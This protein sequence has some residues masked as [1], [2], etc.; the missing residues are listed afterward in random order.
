MIQLDSSKSKRIPVDFA[1]YGANTVLYVYLYFVCSLLLPPLK[2]R[3]LCA[4][5]PLVLLS[6][7][8]LRSSA[9]QAGLQLFSVVCFRI[10][11][12]SIECR[13]KKCRG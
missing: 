13:K 3:V 2:L 12:H 11:K 8:F 10:R 1:I 7:M 4:L 9:P 5:V 6:S